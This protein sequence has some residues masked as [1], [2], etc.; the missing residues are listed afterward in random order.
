M[1][2]G[3]KA[4][5][6]FWTRAWVVKVVSHRAREATTVRI[7][8]LK[9]LIGLLLLVCVAYAVNAQICAIQKRQ[10]QEIQ[11][12]KDAHARKVSELARVKH[13]KEQVASLLEQQNTEFTR[14]LKLIQAQDNE[15]RR[16]V[17]LK[18]TNVAGRN[19]KIKGS[20]GG[21]AINH[22]Q[23]RHQA[24]QSAIAGLNSRLRADP[25]RPA[26]DTR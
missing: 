8:P 17:G 21:Y 12:L 22:Y 15:I 18:P 23:T 10:A 1:S 26:R 13:E 14:K 16:I 3:A 20:R 25:V 4:R 24:L 19:L 7:T 5:R 9:L 2:H 6:G 11:R